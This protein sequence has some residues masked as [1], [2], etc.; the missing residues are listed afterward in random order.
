MVTFFLFQIAYFRWSKIVCN[1]TKNKTICF[2]WLSACRSGFISTF[3][4]IGSVN[5]K[6]PAQ[7][8]PGV[9]HGFD[10]FN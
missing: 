5:R 10:E 9:G 1:E 7:F 8:N 4:P 6:K 2:N 3:M